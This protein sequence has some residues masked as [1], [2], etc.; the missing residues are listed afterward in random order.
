M[1]IGYRRRR[2]SRKIGERCSPMP[3]NVEGEVG[4]QIWLR[5]CSWSQQKARR[6]IPMPSPTDLA[7]IVEGEKHDLTGLRETN[8]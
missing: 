4:F 8:T 7:A 6:M 5:K 3:A 2:Y 1:E